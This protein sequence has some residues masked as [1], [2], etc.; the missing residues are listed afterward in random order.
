M[1]VNALKSVVGAGL[2]VF[3]SVWLL[4]KLNMVDLREWL[5]FWPAILVGVGIALLLEKDGR[6]QARS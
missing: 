2:V 4:D 6:H 3:G 5:E 1:D